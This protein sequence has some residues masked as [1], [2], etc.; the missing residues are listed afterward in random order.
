MDSPTPSIDLTGGSDSEYK[1]SEH[2]EVASSLNMSRD[3]ANTKTTKSKSSSL[4][5]SVPIQVGEGSSA[6][7]SQQAKRKTGKR[8]S[9]TE[10]PTSLASNANTTTPT[11]TAEAKG[12]T[13][14]RNIPSTPTIIAKRAKA[15]NALPPTSQSSSSQSAAKADKRNVL[16]STPP[17]Q[18]PDANVGGASV[19]EQRSPS[20]PSHAPQVPEARWTTHQL[21]TLAS[22]IENSF[23]FEAFAAEWNKTP[24]E[25]KDTYAFLMH[26]TVF[27]YT[28]AEDKPG[29]AVKFEKERV[30]VAEKNAKIMEKV[31]RKER[32]EEEKR[33]KEL[34]KEQG[35]GKG[36]AR[37]ASLPGA[38]EGKGKG[39]EIQ[40]E[41]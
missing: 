11:A 21:H 38:A 5:S 23:D 14:K 40:S 6:S 30:R 16:W 29:V 10:T 15:N 33:M 26:R 18:G 36:K 28:F 37:K 9:K 8:P 22:D 31:H 20:S 12:P 39:K 17:Y 34:A 3:P 27:D 1:T 19:T 24:D 4:N 2:S 7:P 13:L 35:T 41:E 25:V 32:K